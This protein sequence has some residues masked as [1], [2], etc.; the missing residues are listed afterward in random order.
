MVASLCPQDALSRKPSRKAAFSLPI[1][2]YYPEEIWGEQ[3]G[4]ARVLH[5]LPAYHTDD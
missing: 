1:R 5:R 3:D 2:R 4:C